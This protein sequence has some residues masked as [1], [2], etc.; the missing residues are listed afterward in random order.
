LELYT[1]IVGLFNPFALI[2]KFL[3]LLIFK[4]P[5]LVVTEYEFFKGLFTLNG[6]L[7]GLATGRNLSIITGW[8]IY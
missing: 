2:L 4:I 5:S 8:E 1:S 3:S 6:Y 7:M